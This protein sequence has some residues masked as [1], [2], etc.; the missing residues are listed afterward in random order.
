[1]FARPLSLTAAL[2]LAG[3]ALVVPARAASAAAPTAQASSGSSASP[4]LSVRPVAG[5]GGGPVLVAHRGASGYAPENTLAGIDKARE[6]GVRWVEN[7]V[8]RT[9]DG[10]LVVVHD[11]TLA[12]TTD[13]EE[14]FPD[15][16]PWNVRD[17]TFREITRLDAGSW[18]GPRY[19]GAKVP[20]LDQF[21][22][23]MSRQ[24]LNLLLELK[25]PELY[26]GIERETLT[27]L[28]RAGWLD[29]SHVRNRLVVQSFGADAVRRVHQLR[30]DVK[31]GFLG[32]P[33]QAELPAY[34]AFADQINPTHSAVTAS[35]VDAVQ[36]LKGPH[37]KPLE[38]YTWTVNDAATA[39][40]VNDA[41][42]DGVITNFPDV[43]KDAIG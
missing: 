36:A 25:A 14:V 19:R 41:G 42:V 17:F 20:T 12:R 34:A 24:R 4:R 37:G 28:R 13:A 43:V 40:R 10:V 15:R 23:R 26:P 22:E 11:T 21:L 18:F 32:T 16:S 29:R 2:L 6:M 1:M 27:A 5:P 8:Q 7:D 3:T 35:Y 31:T 33:A 38:V 30:P 39:R 9:K